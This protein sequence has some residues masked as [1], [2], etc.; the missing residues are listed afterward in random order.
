MSDQTERKFGNI[1]SNLE[2]RLTRQ[3]PVDK[4]DSSY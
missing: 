3:H 4:Y 2:I 1:V